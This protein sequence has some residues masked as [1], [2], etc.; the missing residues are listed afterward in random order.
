MAEGG[1]NAALG[2]VD[3]EDNWKI[4]M[5][6][7]IKEGVY[8]GNPR[9]VELLTRNAESMILELEKYGAIFDR[10][11]EGRIRQRAFGAQSYRRTCHI[12]DKTGL[13]I[14][15]VLVEQIHKNNI[16][17]MP[18]V[19]VTKLLTVKNKIIGAVGV[20]L[21][22]GEVLIFNAKVI[23]L[24]TGG[25]AKVYKITTNAWE[26][27]GDGIALA[28]D[29]GVELMDMEMI[30][31]HP[32]G[33]IYPEV[34]RGIL[35]TE[36]VRGDGGHLLNNKGERFMKN[37]DSKRMELSARDI[38]ARANYNEIFHG[39]GTKKGGVYL[40]IS[41]KGKKFINKHLPKMVKQFKEFADLDITKEKME[42]APTAH[43]SMG[44]IKIDTETC[45]TKIK[46]LYAA[47]EVTGGVHGSNRLGGNSLMEILVFGKIAGRSAAKYAKK[48]KLT[49][50][51][52][53]EVEK[54]VERITSPLNKKGIRAES[55]KE[56]LQGIMWEKVG[57]IRNEK[58]LQ[59]ALREIKKLKSY[60]K[61]IGVKG[62]LR[63]NH[64]WMSYIDIHNMILVSELIIMSALT[65]KESRGG[66]YR[67]DYKKTDKEWELNIVCKKIEEK[68]NLRK[69]KVPSMKKELRSI[70]N[71]ED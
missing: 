63:Y 31:F 13:E 30:Q 38:V 55:I 27:V 48:T 14:M 57:I 36:A 45:S 53:K 58:D 16:K 4:H 56:K 40:D 20:D 41:H 18:E 7:T 42:V 3:P 33:M 28:Y 54:E 71:E 5:K 49:G 70:L 29:L 24:A 66:H 12:S 68:I 34:A 21:K 59:E 22:S 60:V 52:N 47:G 2:N 19:F 9:M 61:K 37:Y 65:R 62:D 6:D 10:T 44:G 15:N 1:I 35:V 69:E 51:D 23:I 43:Y 25:F 11:E 39:R 64:G 26:N 46:G 50:I 32:T 8:L 67:E 17:N